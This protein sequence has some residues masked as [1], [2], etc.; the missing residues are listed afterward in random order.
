MNIKTIDIIV[1]PNYCQLSLPKAP[2]HK[3]QSILKRLWIERFNEL[4][5]QNDAILLYF[6]FIPYDKLI[7]EL[8]DATKNA[9]IA[10]QDEITTIHELRRSLC[11]RLIVFSWTLLISSD[12][13]LNTLSSRGFTYIP[14]ETKINAYGEIFEVCVTGWAY[15]IASILDIPYSNIVLDP[16]QSLTDYDCK[17][18]SGWRRRSY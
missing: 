4:K 8:H 15:Y 17:E 10:E 5:D 9:N 12:T 3:R 11:E 18:I 2:L 1:H 6:S 14:G 7:L 13:L 16:K